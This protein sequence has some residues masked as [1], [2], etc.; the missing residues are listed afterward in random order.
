MKS[1]YSNIKTNGYDSKKEAQYALKF[2]ALLNSG[3]IIKLNE[4]VKF[5]LIP[6]QNLLEPR[7]V[8][9]KKLLVERERTYIADFVITWKDGK[10]EVVDVKGFRTDIYAL[11]RA[12]MLWVHGIQIKEL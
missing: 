4:Q 12:L 8:N 5:V 1:K 6:K 9:N 3:E 2:K 7:I 11:K 10:T